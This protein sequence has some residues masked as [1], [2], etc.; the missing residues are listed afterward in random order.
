VDYKKEKLLEKV[1]LF[2]KIWYL[3]QND[4]ADGKAASL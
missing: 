4:Y 2:K 3:L 1:N